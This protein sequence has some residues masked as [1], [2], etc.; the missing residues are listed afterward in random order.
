VENLQCL[1]TV[2][3]GRHVAGGGKYSAPYDSTQG[4][5]SF[6]F[7]GFWVVIILF[8]LRLA[9]EYR[10]KIFVKKEDPKKEKNNS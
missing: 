2:Q 4:V 6:I 10:D 7:L 1:I 5:P 9:Y 8:G 3:A